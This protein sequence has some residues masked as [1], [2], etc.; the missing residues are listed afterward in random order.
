MIFVI[1][2]E[3]LSNLTLCAAVCFADKQ[4]ENTFLSGTIDISALIHDHLINDAIDRAYSA[5]LFF[6]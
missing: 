5:Y 2:R 6:S 1:I 3:F 4:N